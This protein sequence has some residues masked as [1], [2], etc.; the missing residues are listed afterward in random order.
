MLVCV[1]GENF[2]QARLS[3]P[4]RRRASQIASVTYGAGWVRCGSRPPC[5][6]LELDTSLIIR[7]KCNPP[8]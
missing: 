3:I 5:G 6:D 4:Q 7:K 8:L 1:S 2:I